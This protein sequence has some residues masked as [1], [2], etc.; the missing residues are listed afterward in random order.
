M[1]T[2]RMGEVKRLLAEITKEAT[3][4]N[5]STWSY[6]NLGRFASYGQL[7]NQDNAFKVLMTFHLTEKMAR[8]WNDR[9]GG[10]SISFKDSMVEDLEKNLLSLLIRSSVEMNE[11]QLITITR[12][13]KASSNY[14]HVWPYKPLMTRIEKHIKL[15][16]LSKS[17]SKT[18]SYLKFTKS[19]YAYAD[20]KEIDKRINQLTSGVEKPMISSK[21]DFG[22][23]I[24]TRL[25][26]MNSQEAGR[27]NMLIE[28]LSKD[29]DKSTPSKKWIAQSRKIVEGFDRREWH[30]HLIPV[31]KVCITRLQT[32]HKRN[33]NNVFFIHEDNVQLLRGMVWIT[34]YINDE[35]INLV[36]EELGLWCFRK[37]PGH[38]ALSVK[39]G[40]ACLYTFSQL[41]QEVGIMRL[42]KF[43]LKIK[44]P[45]V[46]SQIEKLIRK[47]AESEGKTMDQIEELAI[48]DFGLNANN[49]FEQKI[50]E[51]TA[52]L[53]I[54]KINKTEIS[55]LKADGKAQKSI[56]SSIKEEFKTQIGD[57]R[58][59]AKEIQTILPS[60]KDRIE[61]F[62]LKK[63]KWTFADWKRYYHDHN[64]ISFIARNL[65][66]EFT[67]D[68]KCGTG[69]WLNNR[70]IDENENIIDWTSDKTVVRLWHPINS[71][72]DA[73]VKWR[74]I[75]EKEQ[76]QQ[77]F[78]QAF[79]EVYLV[80]DAELET[81]NYSNRFAAHILY[82][83]QFAALCQTRGWAYSLMGQ[84]DSHNT[85]TLKIPQWG[86]TAEYWVDSN[87]D[88]DGV[89]NEM[90][91]F[92]FIHTDQVRFYDKEKQLNIN[93]TPDI[94]FSEVMR[95]VDLF[96][97]VTSIGNDPNWV[98]GG[99]QAYNHYW[100]DYSFGDLSESS[101]IRKQV[102]QNLVPKLKVAKQ[103]QFEG[104]FLVVEGKIRIYKIHI[105]S[106]NILMKPNDQYLCIV[107][108]R[109][110]SADKV[111]LPFEGDRQLSIIISKVFLL[112]ADDKITDRTILRQINGNVSR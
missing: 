37:L 85:P 48:N 100:Q 81:E 8:K 15:Y 90:G 35:S 82:Q 33:S 10:Y 24:N 72:V 57:L 71:P 28:Q 49:Q 41:P 61:G 111:Y 25:K 17:M 7:K 5:T 92:N 4:Q 89:A 78:K 32:I 20:E 88:G 56:P 58:K 69:M 1:D 2:S 109:K 27:W 50:G 6:T 68:E 63:R 60:Q 76:I 30:E 110:S 53:K 45:S 16:G 52:V 34:A 108:D 51:C 99:I 43:R 3:E 66:W 104:N 47:K 80:T 105:G 98:D 67:D 94:V 19:R 9:K 22:K 21:D 31:I 38:G 64:L 101:K 40:N 102:L 46:R 65:I 103:C 70:L 93:E 14:A 11:D 13:F 79:R 91:I 36:I 77:P 54:T 83:H 84:W 55:W 86:M 12:T 59:K 95:D 87:W 97:G 44:Y 23:A 75:L 26:S 74:A 42:T 107:P 18:L 73:I 39:V 106:G 29:K 62:F 112:A 96:V